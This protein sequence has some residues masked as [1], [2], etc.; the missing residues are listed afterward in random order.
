MSLIGLLCQPWMMGEYSI[1][2]KEDWQGKLKYCRKHGMVPLNSPQIPY[3]L[4]LDQT[5]VIIVGSQ[6][7]IT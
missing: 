3:D 2:W 7:L 4:M 5:Q 1:L 6:Q